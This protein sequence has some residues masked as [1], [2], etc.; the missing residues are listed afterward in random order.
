M[1]ISAGGPIVCFAVNARLTRISTTPVKGL[2]LAHPHEIRLE[3]TGATDDRRFYLVD[4]GGHLVN[5]KRAPHLAWIGAT[6][7]DG[8][9]TLAIATPDGEPIEALVETD[10]PVETSFY[11]RAVRGRVVRGPF[12]EAISQAAGVELTLVRADQPGGGHD[13]GP[14]GAVSLVSIA[15]LERLA[16]ELAVTDLD[17]RRFRM[18]FEVAGVEAHEEDGWVGRRIS[19]GEAVV[20][21]HALVG[22]CA[23]TTQ[24]PDSGA[25]D[26]DTLRALGAYRADVP[27]E[28]PLPFG[29]WGSVETPGVVR[30]GDVVAPL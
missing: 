13:R 21:L 18:L 30:V 19:I 4:G 14:A 24:D 25:S 10:R 16:A 8:G 23:V 9:S 28:E 22:R 15:S 20:R 17:A 11:G 29:V 1:G 12:S 27:S 26:L 6:L 7:A 5:R 3:R 2:A